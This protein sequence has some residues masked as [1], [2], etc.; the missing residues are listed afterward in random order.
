M[1][2]ET[3]RLLSHKLL[4]GQLEAK[5]MSYRDLADRSRCG[6]SMIGY[7]ASGAKSTCTAELGKRIAEAVGLDY[8][9]LFAPAP[10]VRR[11]RPSRQQGAKERAA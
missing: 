2:Q 11:G 1:P 10:S 5:N 9:V 7:L 8:T 6:K 4:Q 3:V